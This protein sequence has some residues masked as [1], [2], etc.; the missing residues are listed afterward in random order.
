MSGV[1]ICQGTPWS[2][3]RLVAC[4]IWS[5]ENPRFPGHR[6][7]GQPILHLQ[8]VWHYADCK[9]WSLYCCCSTTVV[10]HIT[11]SFSRGLCSHAFGHAISKSFLTCASSLLSQ[12]ISLFL[13]GLSLENSRSSL[14]RRVF[15]LG[16][17][18]S[19]RPP[20]RLIPATCLV[21]RSPSEMAKKT[22]SCSSAGSYR[23][24]VV[25]KSKARKKQYCKSFAAEHE[26]YTV[27]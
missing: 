27:S 25:L 26:A 10:H 1:N 18:I 6:L 15:E 24:S 16:R 3:E 8:Q 4:A 2:E 22:S 19:L 20:D 17:V 11:L 13:E 5:Q 14:S 23:T 9:V 7:H 21:K 12:R